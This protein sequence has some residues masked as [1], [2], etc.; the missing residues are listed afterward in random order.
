M[1]SR[2][3][4][5]LTYLG[6]HVVKTRRLRNLNQPAGGAPP[7]PGFARIFA[8]E[9]AGNSNSHALQARIERRFHGSF[10]FISSYTWSHAIDDRPN[11]GGGLPQDNRNLR[12]ERGDADFDARHH[13]TFSSVWDAPFGAGRRWGTG[14]TGLSQALLGGWGVSVIGMAQSGR[15]L[16][17]TL[18]SNNSGAGNLADRPN[19]VA[20]V[21]WIP[22]NQSPD[23]WINPAAF[24]IPSAGTFGNLGRNTVRGP[25][26]QNVDISLAKTHHLREDLRLQFR[27]ELFNALNHPNFAPP[28][29]QLDAPTT[30]GV[31]SSTV[32]N[33]RQIQ[34]GVRLDY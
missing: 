1:Q 16:S 20:G 11:H 33:Q 22:T 5:E 19:A 7:F 26:I 2:T 28:A 8:Y 13:W 21:N 9:Q 4:V 32:L 17:V 30:F 25:G 3:L 23:Q 27:A 24:S 10:G 29:T 6:N 15:P 14:W 31:I 18:A 34:F 12:A